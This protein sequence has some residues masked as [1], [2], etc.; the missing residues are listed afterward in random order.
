MSDSR[1]SKEW[2]NRG[3]ELIATA[4]A[5]ATFSTLVALWRVIVRLRVN[6]WLGVSDWLMIGGVILNFVSCI[7]YAILA[8]NGGQG[9]LMADPWWQVPGHTSNELHIIFISQC[10]NV[11][12]MFLVKASICAYLMALNLGPSYRVLIWISV[13]IVV[14]LNFIM[15]LILHFAYCR[16]YWSRWDFSVKGEC[17]PAAV[18]EWTAYFQIASNI[19]TDLIYA[20]APIIYLRHVQLSK[21]TQWGVR[22]VFLLALVGTA[23]SIVKIPT[24]YRFLRSK[25]VMWDAI[26]LS[27]CSINEVC[28]GIVIANLPPLRKTINEFLSKVLPT[29]FASSAGVASR[30]QPSQIVLSSMTHSSKGHTKLDNQGDSESERYILGLEDRKSLGISRA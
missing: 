26:D 2:P 14:S 4:S 6:P 25:E 11:Y 15:M 5:M 9:R 1:A 7:P 20:A 30:K 10:L 21:R 3:H 22:I 8:A 29:K 19:V 18:S 24:T 28:V 16:P 17:W 27:I 13:F 23:L 12:A